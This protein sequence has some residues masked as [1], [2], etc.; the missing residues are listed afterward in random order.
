MGEMDFFLRP[1]LAGLCS[2]T[3][4]KDGTLTYG[5]LYLLNTALN[6]KAEN[7]YRLMAEYSYGKTHR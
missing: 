5:D 7:E 2:Y 6:I 4:I 1:V 3:D